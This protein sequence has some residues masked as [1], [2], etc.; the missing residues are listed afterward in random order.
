MKNSERTMEN[1]LYRKISMHSYVEGDVP[2]NGQ[3]EIIST[4]GN[5][6]RDTRKL[7][8]FEAD[9]KILGFFRFFHY[10]LFN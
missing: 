2:N 1:I 3:L 8:G 4:Y 9:I 5:I 10:F 7:C 6:F